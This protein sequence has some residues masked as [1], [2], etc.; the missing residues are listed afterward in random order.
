LEAAVADTPVTELTFGGGCP[1]C[2]AREAV[3][4]GPLARTGDDFE[5]RERD[6]EAFRI[7]MLEELA[8]RFPERSRW[9][10]ADLE[11][12]LVEALAAVLD[13]LS[14][15]LDR[16]SAE[17]CLETARRPE[18]VRRLLAMIGF[19]AAKMELLQ[20]D[21]P[22][23][24]NGLTAARKLERLWA[25]N[26]T[27][28]ESARRA[29]PLSVH[30]QKRMVT[31]SDYSVRL[32]EHPLVRRAAARAFWSGSWST[33]QVA[34]IL[35]WSDIRLDDPLRLT[36]DLTDAEERRAGLVDEAMRAAITAFHEQ[37]GIRVPDWDVRPRPTPRTVLGTCID[38][39]RMTGQEVWLQDAVPV[40]IEMGLT[41]RVADTCFQSEVRRAVRDALGTGAGA[42]FERGRLRFGEDLHASDLFQALMQLDGVENVCLTR[43]KRA[44]GQFEDCAARGLIALTDLE[45]AVCDNNPKKAENGYY[46]LSL[47]GGRA[48]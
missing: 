26:P 15:M 14:D 22:E 17:A 33:L 5:W 8:A 3:L 12:V 45:I 29:G 34:V 21:P 36:M 44:G 35:P 28:M 42:F 40:A 24:P 16:V 1:D 2:G 6:H 27:R 39:F 18:S 19:D 7:G 10:P 23:Q 43:F 47:V 37:R 13:Q 31:A 48:G 46:R 25:A 11:V 20:D 9:T 38:V 41:V 30:D 32:E 4:P